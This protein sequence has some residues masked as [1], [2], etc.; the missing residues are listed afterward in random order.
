[1]SYINV[2]ATLSCFGDTLTHLLPGRRLRRI[3]L[4]THRGQHFVN[5]K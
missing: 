1:M 3:E 5:L 4:W 2:F